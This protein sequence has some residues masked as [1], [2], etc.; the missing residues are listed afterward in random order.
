L[1]GSAGDGSPAKRKDAQDDSPSD[2]GGG[3]E[4]A[5]DARGDSGGEAGV[6][7]AGFFVSTTGSD[8]NPG[9]LMQ[10][11]ATIARAQSAMQGSPTVK[12]TYV[13]AGTYSIEPT[14][15]L[16]GCGNPAAIQLSSADSGE[17]L[18]A[19][20]PDGYGTAI[21][22]G[23]ATINT[24]ICILGA[25]ITVNGLQIQGYGANGILSFGQNMLFENNTVHDIQATTTSGGGISLQGNSANSVVRHNYV[26]N[27]ANMGIEA[28]AYVSGGIDN[29]L[30]EYNFVDNVCTG[31]T[32]CGALYTID[33]NTTPSTGVVIRYNYARDS[34]AMLGGSEHIYL[35]LGTSNTQSYGNV[36]TGHARTCWHQNNGVNNIE[37]NN[38]CDLSDMSIGPMSIIEYQDYTTSGI[39]GSMTGDAITGNIFIA[40]SASTG[41]GY[42]GNG[43]PGSSF[44]P[45]IENNA[46]YNY[47]GSGIDDSGSGGMNGDASPQS[48]DPEISCWTYDILGT[49]PVL[50]SPVSFPAQPSTWGEPG[51]WGPPR[52][53]VPHTGTPPSQ[54]HGC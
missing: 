51:F 17:T 53:T 6:L 5:E 34:A 9:T 24:A 49:S 42:A 3:S 21:L 15:A 1:D 7:P 38:I 22:D 29:L 44:W 11:F 4:T 45:T 39:Y 25:N 41:G 31:S 27:M 26:Y 13:R 18:S 10:P 19:Y 20:P 35:D 47:V 30:Y 37:K 43:I 52:F 32:D 33:A 16:T 23:T 12:I 28:N 48:L 2:A 8:G 50:S 36:L 14:K 46:Y 40:G 54:P